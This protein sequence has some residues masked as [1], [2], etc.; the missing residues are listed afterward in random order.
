MGPH[1]SLYY[2]AKMCN[3]S[4]QMLSA[5]A[6]A[7]IYTSISLGVSCGIVLLFIVVWWMDALEYHIV[8]TEFQ[9]QNIFVRESIFELDICTFLWQTTFTAE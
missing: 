1:D 2:A 6:L 5:D 7:D 3:D 9:N 8:Q 4:P